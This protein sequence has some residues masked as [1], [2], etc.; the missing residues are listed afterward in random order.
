MCREHSYPKVI[1]DFDL[2]YEI[3]EPTYCPEHE[4]LVTNPPAVASV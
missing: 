4:S 3:V 1:G 2:D